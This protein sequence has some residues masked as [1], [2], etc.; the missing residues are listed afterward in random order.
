MKRPYL[1]QYQRELIRLDTLEG[2]YIMIHFRYKQ[3]ERSLVQSKIFK[4]FD[5]IIRKIGISD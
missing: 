1:K 2:H 3:L 4:H 5:Y